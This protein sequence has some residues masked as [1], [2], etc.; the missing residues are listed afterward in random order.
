MRNNP[1]ME[2][3]R[4]SLTLPRHLHQYLEKISKADRRTPSDF[5]AEWLKR[6]MANEAE[7]GSY[8]EETQEAAK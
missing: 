8:A 5:I 3:I 2:Q 7:F 1:D 4:T 6:R